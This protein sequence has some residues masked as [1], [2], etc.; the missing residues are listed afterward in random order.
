MFTLYISDISQALEDE[1]DGEEETAEFIPID[2]IDVAEEEEESD[3]EERPSSPVNSPK[4]TG[5]KPTTKTSITPVLS[6]SKLIVK[7]VLCHYLIR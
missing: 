1:Q 3:S 6:K 5:Q 2:S 7:A 4:K